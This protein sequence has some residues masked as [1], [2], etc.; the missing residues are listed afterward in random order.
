MQLCFPSF[1]RRQFLAV[2][3]PSPA[4]GRLINAAMRDE[5]DQSVAS[6]N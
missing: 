6:W 4:I 5:A 2:L 1:F 3:L